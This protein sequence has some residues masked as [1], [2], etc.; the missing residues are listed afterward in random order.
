[1]ENSFGAWTGV[2]DF[3]IPRADLSESIENCKGHG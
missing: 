3:S 1:M 2:R